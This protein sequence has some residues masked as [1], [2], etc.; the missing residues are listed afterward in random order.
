MTPT[1]GISRAT[2]ADGGLTNGTPVA[3]S[4]K[5]PVPGS[6][7]S[8]PT[9]ALKAYKASASS[10]PSGTL[11]ARVQATPIANELQY[12]RKVLVKSLAVA[13]LNADNSEQMTTQIIAL[14]E[15]V[16]KRGGRMD[17]PMEERGNK[18]FDG[19]SV[20]FLTKIC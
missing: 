11:A 17:K 14:R 13:N 3:S 16:N 18:N 9:T 1:R 19:L 7:N 20:F 6:T 10:S 15:K 8:P 5:P 12:N 4:Q 2:G